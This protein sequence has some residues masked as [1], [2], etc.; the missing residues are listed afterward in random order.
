MDSRTTSSSADL[1]S[2]HER[3]THHQ[4]R[5]LTDVFLF[6]ANLS[7]QIIRKGRIRSGSNL[8]GDPT[9]YSKLLISQ[10]HSL[11]LADKFTVNF[12]IENK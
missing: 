2:R 12:S 5:W 11:Y 10:L 9:N 3:P 6:D 8:E 7:R 4:T 1:I